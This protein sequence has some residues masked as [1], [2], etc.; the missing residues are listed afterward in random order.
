MIDNLYQ[1]PKPTPPGR[2]A[3]G[4]S[5]FA[6]NRSV[7]YRYNPHRMPPDDVV[8]T[9]TGRKQLLEDLRGRVTGSDPAHVFLYGPRGIGKTTMLLMLRYT[10]AASPNLS[11][12]FDIVQFSEEER[13]VANLPS[14]AVRILERLASIRPDAAADLEKARD[15]ALS[16]PEETMD[17]L[18]AAGA[19]RPDRQILLLLDNFDELVL[20][21]VS[22]KSQRF[23]AADINPLDKLAALLTC[24]RFRIVA[25]AL[26]PPEKRKNFP[27]SLLA[28][29]QPP[30]RLDPLPDAAAFLRRRAAKDRRDGFL[31]RLPAL[32][33][34]IAGLNRLA[35]GN[36]RLLVFLYE[37]LGDLP[38]LDLVDLVQRILDDLTPMYQDVL[39]RLVNPGQAAVLEMLAARGGVGTAE[40]IAAVTY[41]GKQTV[42]TAL[43]DLADLGLVIRPGAID[44]PGEPE[45]GKGGRVIFRTHPPLFQIWYEMRHFDHPHSLLLVRFLSHITEPGEAGRL[46]LDLRTTANETM[47]SGAAGVL[48]ELV[49][50]LDPEWN[51]LRDRYLREVLNAGGTHAEALSRLAEALAATGP[52]QI[53]RRIGL[54]VIRSE[55]RRAL[56]DP[57]GAGADLDAAEA[58]AKKSGDEATRIRLL[59][60]RSWWL[61]SADRYAEAAAA[62]RDAASLCSGSAMTCTPVLHGAALL[63][64]ASALQR[65]GKLKEAQSAATDAGKLLEGQDGSRLK[66]AFATIMAIIHY[67]LGEYDRARAGHERALSISQQIRDRRGQAS[68]LNNLGNVCQFLDEYAQAREYHEQSLAINQ[69]IGDCRG[70]ASSLGNL[71]N[72][73]RSFGE[74]TQA[75]EYYEQS[76]AIQQKVGDRR[77]Q[78]SSLDNLG[79]VYQSIG[80]FARAREYH[81]QALAIRQEIGDRQGRAN[82]LGNLG[83]VCQSL[84]EYAQA[85]ECYEQSMAIQQEIGNRRGQAASLNNLGIVYHALGEYAHA[86]DHIEQ[87]LAIA[88]EIGDRHTQAM[89]LG[90]LGNVYAAAEGRKA[91]LAFF[92]KA[93]SLFT[94]I[95]SPYIIQ[96]AV[97]TVKTLFALAAAAL[98]TE[99]LSSAGAYIDR[100]FDFIKAIGPERSLSLLTTELVIPCLQVSRAHARVLRQMLDRGKAATALGPDLPQR[101][102]IMALLRYYAKERS[103]NA[104]RD[105]DPTAMSVIQSLVDRIERPRHVKA[106]ELLKAGK[107]DEASR[108]YAELL[109]I[110][111]EDVEAGLNLASALAGKNRL[112]EAEKKIRQVLAVHKDLVPARLL[113]ADIMSRQGSTEAA[114]DVL[115]PLL[116]D[117]GLGI[118][119]FPT[120]AQLLRRLKRFGD[121][122]TTLEK[123]RS[124][125]S[126]EPDRRLDV[127]IPEAWLLAGRV[128]RAK[129]CMPPE[130][131]IPKAPDQRLLLGLLRVFI[132]LYNRDADKAR[133][134]AA[135]ILAFASDLPT[136]QDTNVVDAALLKSAREKLGE[137]EF[138]F[139]AGLNLA[140]SGRVSPV[141]Y[142]HEYLSQAE[143]DELTR[144]MGEER[145]TVIEALSAGRLQGFGDLFRVSGRK[146]GPAAGISALGDAFKNLSKPV[147]STVLEILT[148]AV[149]QGSPVEAEAALGAIGVNFPDLTPLR[150]AQ[151]LTAV[152]DLIAAGES[153]RANRE[154]ALGMLNIL[155]PNL[156]TQEREE[157]RQAV[158]AVREDLDGPE[159]AEFLEETVPQTREG[160]DA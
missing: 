11:R 156:T 138:A 74:Y 125:L 23:K 55:V 63:A 142:A 99:G 33:G 25:T 43:N 41:Q 79:I 157:A 159:M 70:Q 69:Q 78:A 15:A 148:A 7:I 38:L 16:V 96:S 8:D 73:C 117:S 34:R 66:M 59:T 13:R 109:E 42:L 28:H 86:R 57:E 77:G 118:E 139:L 48:E 108:I 152:L 90:S 93:H 5:D 26:Q 44:L 149:K 56:G 141:E 4:T 19:R 105:L 36:P 127:W 111:P 88:E 136:D 97:H 151:C 68:S 122:A 35:A 61:V 91:A 67:D 128:D 22:G 89:V 116:D 54:H 40:D 101:R 60:A 17:H 29:F 80:E 81:G 92:E 21:V 143:V 30:V 131:F 58:I 133:E 145:Q 104:F 12:R 158:E 20:A 45:K 132:A 150:R 119:A 137:R 114:G 98:E 147:Q 64:L 107:A 39:D 140:V 94:A 52:D 14:F 62:A 47:S 46:F 106:R 135:R 6:I 2:E 85:R 110:A 1:T 51:E 9:F 134:Q 27:K 120:M 102:L 100:A 49:L 95:G 124:A 18:L 72:V 71:G 121:L 24:G 103:R 50:A 146:I 115:D 31:E 112:D 144:R 3:G 76:L 75:R 10:I 87:A 154:N 123:W 37:C 83:N 32:A 155:Y 82:S 160:E 113:L 130:D 65:L 53:Q 153:L 126:A 84:G 129:T